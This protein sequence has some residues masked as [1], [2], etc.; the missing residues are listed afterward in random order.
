MSEFKWDGGDSDAVVLTWQPRVAAYR[1]QQNG[2]IVRQ[3]ADA[4]SDD[5]GDDQVF[6][7]PMGALQI[8]W[9]LIELAHEC[10]IPAPPRKLMTQP[11]DLG[12]K[13]S[14]IPLTHPE[15]VSAEAG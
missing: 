12:P 15:P 3:E 2:I 4:M 13:Q 8:G 1:N 9:R 6:L 7:T 5:R 11:L 10:G 14:P